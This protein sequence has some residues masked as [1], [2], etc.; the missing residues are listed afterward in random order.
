MSV[1]PAPH[2]S[3]STISPGAARTGNDE[4]AHGEEGARG[5]DEVQED[6]V[7]LCR[8]KAIA[9]GYHTDPLAGFKKF[10]C[11]GARARNRPYLPTRASRV[12]LPWSCSWP[13]ATAYVTRAKTLSAAHGQA[14]L[15]RDQMMPPRHMKSARYPSLS[16]PPKAAPPRR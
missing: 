11:A 4:E 3:P 2:R 6:L 10:P 14:T 8:G 5:Y 7:A 16:M 1:H 12:S 15:S 13:T 9:A